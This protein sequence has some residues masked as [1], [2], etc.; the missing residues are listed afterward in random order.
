[1]QFQALQ[2]NSGGI[3]TAAPQMMAALLAQ[4]RARQQGPQQAQGMQV[5]GLTLNKRQYM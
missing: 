3:A 2:D 1:M 4:I 5:P